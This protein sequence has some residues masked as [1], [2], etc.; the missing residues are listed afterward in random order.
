MPQASAPAAPDRPLRLA[1][2]LQDLEFGGTQ[3]YA[4]HLMRGLDRRL[5]DPELWV[6]NA[7]DGLEAEALATGA[8]LVRISRRP[9]GSP[10]ALPP[11]FA[12][13]ARSRPDILYTLTVVPNI[14]GRLFGRALGVPAITAGFRE[15]KPKQWE[16][17]LWRVTDR[18][19]CNAEMLRERAV[20]TLGVPSDRVTVV[21]N[22]VDSERFCSAA[23]PDGPPR[24]VSVARLVRDKSPLA[25]V[26]AFAIALQSVPE[27]CLTLVGD[28]PLRSKV[29]A[30]LAE[31]GI[32]Q[33]VSIVTGCG[34]VRPHLAQAD[35]FAL[36]S[37]REG[38]PNAVLEAM[39]AGLPVAA[40]RTG[41]IPDLVEHGRTG[42][43]TRPEDSEDMGAAL[44]RLLTDKALRCAMGAA[45]REK[46]VRKHSPEATVRATEAALL[47]AWA[48]RR[49]S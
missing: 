24:V 42:L 26:E 13:I 2:L 41:G 32:S 30:R 5:F 12:R 14:W 7:G 36:A 18:L 9:P 27:A 45:G 17:L 47:A 20:S 10:L 38:S 33:A 37:R 22:C 34:E 25:M 3:R 49:A 1:V 19:I 29:E 48:R 16:P 15:M 4:L 11:L 23:R 8:P 44:T 21:P 6:L 46:A 39:A 40:S 31:L 43:L 35:V 28:G